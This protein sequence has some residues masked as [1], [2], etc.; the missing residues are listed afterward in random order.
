MHRSRFAA[1]LCLV[2]LAIVAPRTVAAQ[3]DP[4]LPAAASGRIDKATYLRLRADHVATL[5]GL[6]TPVPPHARSIAIRSL[7]QQERA[8]T[9]A[10]PRLSTLVWTPI[11]PAPIPN[12]QTV[13]SSVPVSGRVTAIAVHPTD[14]AKVYVGTAYGGVYRSLDGGTTW[15]PIMD[16][17]LSLAV[18][19]LALD[20]ADPTRLWVGTGEGNNSGDSYYGVGLYRIAAAESAAPLLE[21]P[22]T[23]DENGND[24]FTYAA[25]T[26]ILIHPAN[27]NTLFVAVALGYFTNGAYSPPPPPLGL[28]R[29]Q[30]ALAADPRFSRLAVP[31]APAGGDPIGDAVLEP[32]NPDHLL[33]T[34]FS[35]GDPS[36]SGIW[37]TANA[38]AAAPAFSR[39]LALPVGTRGMLAADKVGATVNVAVTSGEPANSPR[40]AAGEAGALR[41][42]TD[43]GQTWGPPL[44][45]VAGFCGGQCNYDAPV[46]LD[47]GNP[48]LVYVGGSFDAGRCAVSFTRTTDG[49]QSFSAAGTADSGLHADTH[50]IVVAAANPAVIYLGNDGGI[51]K[52]TDFGQTWAD[53]NNS[54][55]N[56]TQFYSLATHPVDRELMI[57]GTQDNGTPLRKPDGSWTQALGS[58]G[59]F[60]V[61]DGNAADTVS[62]NLYGTY[63]NRVNPG[64]FMGL[65]R[66]AGGA[67]A[68]MDGFW[69][70]RGCGTGADPS[71]NCD[72]APFAAANGLS[73]D[74]SAVLFF[75]PMVR[76]PGQPNSL[77]FGTDR[78]YRSLDRGDTMKVVSQQFVVPSP[79]QGPVPVSAIAIAPGDDRIRL[80]GLANGKVFLTTSGAASFADV[81]GAIPQ[82]F[83]ARIAIDPGDAGVAYVTLDGYTG[84]A[85]QAVWKTTALT[86]GSPTW[87]PAGN[88]IP[89]VPV[90]AFVID[91]AN[92]RHLFAGTDV[93]VFYSQDGGA[94]W[95]PFSNGLPRVPVFD[96]AFQGAQH[97]LRAATHGRGIWEITPPGAVAPC[98]ASGTVLCIDDQPGDAR[99]QVQVTYDAGASGSGSGKAVDLASL[100]VSHGGLFWFFSLDNPELLIKLLNGCALN[101]SFWVF[102]AA[103]TNVGFIVTVTDTRTGNSKTYSNPRGTAAPPLQDTAALPCP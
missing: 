69:A 71:P 27:P 57:G 54:Q 81:T 14:P 24:V 96:L 94:Q 21:G 83:I 60:T 52:S 90:N 59:G 10:D 4:D 18:G 61:I 98:V 64:G 12:G 36:L 86:S 17:A 5:R 55:F 6:K 85:G 72:G 73:C 25:I 47:P 102:Y 84:K 23:L 2:L 43:G 63:F 79:N 45:A 67:C 1:S 34:V 49:G 56:A 7:E 70:F 11:G 48:N 8:R 99:W 65:L 9:R 42:S 51:F 44:A 87:Q 93:G 28:Y 37:R 78:L 62:F 35:F 29:S 92:T 77:Y 74:D 26:K 41:R 97:V 50:A 46:A 68:A 91:P 15:T 40:C 19:A 66:A 89:D 3:H 80:V 13:G 95:L 39:T 75:A 20:P 82:R 16:Q 30:N 32:G 103:G 76:G 88:G 31:N 38:N 53:L 100:G 33:C 58:D 101:Q 22:F